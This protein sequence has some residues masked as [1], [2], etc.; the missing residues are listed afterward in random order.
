MDSW[1][2]FLFIVPLILSL[3]FVA[4]SVLGAGDVDVDLDIDV[5]ADMDAHP[6]PELSDGLGGLRILSAIGIGKAPLSVVLMFLLMLFGTIGFSA[7]QFLRTWLSINVATLLSLFL[8]T[9]IAPLLTRILA[10]HLGKRIPATETYAT[11]PSDF[12]GA[13]GVVELELGDHT[14]IV[15]TTD[16]HGTL[17]KLRCQPNSEALKR[18]QTVIITEPD[19]SQSLFNA[20]TLNI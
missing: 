12:I 15:R 19:T 6:D 2:P 20:T 5:D 14:V 13:T 17:H 3:V 4:S 18:G 10:Q 16:K 11:E 7:L 1:H 8:A 9:A